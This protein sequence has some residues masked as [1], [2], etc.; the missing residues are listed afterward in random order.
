MRS[1]AAIFLPLS[2]LV[3]VAA[4]SSTTIINHVAADS[5]GGVDDTDAGD[6]V[7]DG[8]VSKD[9]GKKDA[10]VPKAQNPQPIPPVIYNGGPLLTAASLVSVTFDNDTLRTTIESFD[11]S[12]GTTAWWDAVR[13]GFC[14]GNGKN[15]VG[16]TKGGGHVHLPAASAQ[17]NYTDSAGGGASTIQTMISGYIASATFPAPTANSL[18]MIYFP[19]SSTISLDGD[20]SCQKFGGYHN[21]MKYNGVQFAY[22]IMPRCATGKGA[23]G[24]LDQLTTAASHELAEAATDPFIST[25]PQNPYTGYGGFQDAWDVLAG[26]EVGDRCFDMFGSGAD[27]IK[28]GSYTVQR[29]FNNVAAKGGHDPCVPAPS[30]ATQ[31]YFNV[32]PVGD[33]DVFSVPVGQTTTFQVQGIADAPTSEMGFLASEY[34]SKFGKGSDVL[35]VSQT[36]QAIAVGGKATITVKLKSNPSQGYALILLEA[37]VTQNGPIHYW[38]VVIQPM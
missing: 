16:Q 26:G 24:D 9:A 7:V 6:V 34:T 15:C 13:A 3:S 31:P 11:D 37:Q 27:L 28:S 10:S 1:S 14:D 18:Y 19:A 29:I 25:D 12:I 5:D 22:A 30:P 21:S 33:G 23:Q 2:F 20:V 4:C 38:P 32:A 17:A 36:S 8:G 35:T